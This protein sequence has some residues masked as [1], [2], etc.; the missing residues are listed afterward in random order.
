MIGVR[1]GA[2]PRAR[3]AALGAHVPERVVTNEEMAA[4]VDTSDE[5]I[6]TRTGIRER[7]F[8]GE[9]QASSDLGVIA[10]QK[11]LDAA[12]IAPDELDMIICPTASPDHI[13]PSTASLI[14]EQI[15]ARGAAAFDLSAACTGFIYGLAMATGMVE[16]GLARHVL[17]VGAETLTRVTDQTDRATCVLF[18]DGAAGALISAADEDEATGFLGFE[19][20]ADGSGGPDL[21]IPAGGSRIPALTNPSRADSCIN[22]NGREVFKFATRVMIDSCTRLLEA[23]EMGID[24]VDLLVPHQANIRIIDYAVERLGIDPERVFNNVDRYG[25][26]SSASIPLALT[27]AQANGR[28]SAGDLVMMVGFGGGLTWGST[29]VRYEPAS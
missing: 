18:G 19:L 24:E 23:L 8:A 10:S 9:D 2:R 12:G 28:L 1:N 14:G 26:T 22:M 29:L 13:F 20:G 3:F 11:I 4:A 6:T 25:N 17:V 7:R 21:I 15:G 27:E 5:W 16:T